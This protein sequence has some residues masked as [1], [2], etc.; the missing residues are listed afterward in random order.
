VEIRRFGIGHRRPDGPPGTV[1]VQGAPIHADRHG[2][3]AEL[4][5][6]PNASVSPHS[7]ANLAYV[8]VIEG[9]GFVQVGD[10]KARVAAGEAVVW[11]PDVIH[12]VWTETTPMRAVVV[13]FAIRPNDDALTLVAAEAQVTSEA[14]AAGEGSASL[15]VSKAEGSLAPRPPVGPETHESTEREPW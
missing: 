10:E 8:V 1:G 2:L 15:G 13:E 3:V 6:R 14:Q 12:A 5:L 7:N 4:A 9:G 11:P